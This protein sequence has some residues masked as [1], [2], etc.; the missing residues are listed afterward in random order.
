VPSSKVTVFR[1][2]QNSQTVSQRLQP[3][4]SG[5]L[6][7]NIFSYAPSLPVLCYYYK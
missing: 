5:I 6:R 7:S 1:E 4:L 2:L 3:V